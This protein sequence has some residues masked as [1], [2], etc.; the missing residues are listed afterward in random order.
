MS[1]ET[2]PD[3]TL[4]P[5]VIIG[6]PRSGTTFLTRMVNRF[7]DVHV[8]RDNGTLV[9]IHRQ[10]RHYEPLAD[11]ANFRR[12][13]RHLYADHFIRERLIA[14]GLKLSEEEIFA[15]VP[16]RRYSALIETVFSAIATERRKRC[17]GYKR[18]SLARMKGEHFNELFPTAKFVHIIRDARE[19]ALSMHRTRTA[20]LERSWHFGAVD[21]VSH[22]SAGRRIR[23]E[24]GAGRYVEL[25]YERLMAEPAVVLSE[26]LDYCGGGSDRDARA[27]R[28]HR[29]AGALVKTENTE[30]WRT[31]APAAGVRQVER[32]AGPLL[33]ELGYSLAH[34]DISGAPIGAPELAWLHANRVVSNLFQ[35]KLGVM[36]RYRLEVLKERLRA[37]VRF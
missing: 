14:R 18:A 36:G 23:D 20:A 26:L 27:E 24:V 37:R 32:V 33:G 22:V 10:L 34:P 11:D 21:W 9:R 28:I 7:F 13:I 4:T 3:P 30:K 29:E 2:A 25:R 1:S 31:L 17:W 8:S 16:E 15:R 12:L 5:L 35:T 19:V 6:S